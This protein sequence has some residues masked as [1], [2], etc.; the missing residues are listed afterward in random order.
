ML[1]GM[2]HLRT[3]VA[4]DACQG[5]LGHCLMMFL[6][7]W[8]RFLLHIPMVGML[9]VDDRNYDLEAD[10]QHFVDYFKLL[11]TAASISSRRG[12]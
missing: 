11:V 5:L 7:M 6:N 3:Y 12:C 8:P 9:I 10:V 2:I 1:L 4:Y